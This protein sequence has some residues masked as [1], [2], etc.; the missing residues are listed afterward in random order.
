[1]GDNEE[2]WETR[3]ISEKEQLRIKSTGEGSGAD[4]SQ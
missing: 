1:M 2:N 4:D 3:L